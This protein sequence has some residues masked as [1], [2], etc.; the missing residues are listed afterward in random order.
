MSPQK[1]LD[2][3]DSIRGLAIL[4]VILVH[5]GQWFPGLVNMP[6]IMFEYG[7]M[8][9]QL[10]FVASAFTLTLSSSQRRDESFYL[11]KFYI[12]RFFRIAPVYYFGIL[13]YLLVRMA[14]E[15][16]ELHAFQWPADYTFSAILANIFLVHGFVPEANNSIVPGGWSIGTEVAFY[17]IFPFYLPVIKR[18]A[19]NNIIS[20]IG[21]NIAV[22][23][24]TLLSIRGIYLGT[25]NYLENNSFLYFN[26]LNQLPVFTLGISYYS[27]WKTD[28]KSSVILNFCFF[29]GFTSLSVYLWLQ[30]PFIEQFTLVPYTAGISFLFLIEL[31]RRIAWLNSGLLMSI[32]KH[33]YT[34]YIIHIL[35][36]YIFSRL[37]GKFLKG[38]DLLAAPSYVVV[39]FATFYT[40][41]FLSRYIESPFINYGKKVCNRFVKREIKHPSLP[42]AGVDVRAVPPVENES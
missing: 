20:H 14:K 10:F 18:V 5:F 22:L 4:L 23:I 6:H 35:I 2:F 19:G 21:L 27:Y 36:V 40:A 16:Q 12:R 37:I 8:G 26:L 38:G 25:G 11:E 42:A 17:F 33:S 3:V 9:V 34:M 31:F 32:G 7:Q 29:L 13:L 30:Q 28:C 41:K 15:S 24:L 39:V 1:N